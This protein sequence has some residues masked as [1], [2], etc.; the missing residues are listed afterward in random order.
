MI[1][2]RVAWLLAERRVPSR[3]WYLPF[4]MIQGGLAFLALAEGMPGGR[5]YLAL[6]IILLLQTLRPTFLG[7]TLAMLG[8]FL[9]WFA[10]PVYASLAYMYPFTM[11]FLILWGLV[12]IA[13][14]WLIRPRAEFPGS[15]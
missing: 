14:L 10:L 4:L 3:W 15:G 2:N 1:K 5:P 6:S 11:G 8:W 12:P 9:V 7:S 13:L